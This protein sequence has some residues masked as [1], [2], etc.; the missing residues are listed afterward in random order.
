MSDKTVFDAQGREV[1]DAERDLPFTVTKADVRG[2]KR[3]NGR[4]CVIACGL[5]RS[6][7]DLFVDAEVGIRVTKV[8]Q[9]GA[10]TR[11]STPRVLRKALVSFDKGDGWNLEPGTYSLLAC[12]E[13][14]K[15][16]YVAAIGRK[17]HGKRGESRHLG[18]KR[19]LPSRTVSKLTLAK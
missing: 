7:G 18:K 8:F 9:R 12:I 4:R 5:T 11:Y 2:A 14:D 10:V 13:S 1:R 15:L 16:F 17:I 19:R 3:R 6:M